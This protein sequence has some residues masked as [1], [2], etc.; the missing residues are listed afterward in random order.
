MGADAGRWADVVKADCASSLPAASIFS[1][2]NYVV[3]SPVPESKWEQLPSAIAE[4]PQ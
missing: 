4:S 3:I 2:K 1:V